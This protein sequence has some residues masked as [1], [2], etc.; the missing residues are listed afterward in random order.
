MTDH[1]ND[2]FMS[3]MHVCMP[4]GDALDA[5]AIRLFVRNIHKLS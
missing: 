5:M 2:E 4:L 1:N 3:S